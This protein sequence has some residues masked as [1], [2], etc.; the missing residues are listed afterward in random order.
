M[1]G[2][3][4]FGRIGTDAATITV[5]ACS[6]STNTG[7][8]STIELQI[9]ADS[10]PELEAV[11]AQFEC[12]PNPD[13][14]R[15]PVRLGERY[16]ARDGNYEV[17]SVTVDRGVTSGEG[18]LMADVTLELVKFDGH[19][20]ARS[21]HLF[22]ARL[23]DNG[24]SVTE[25]YQR[26]HWAIPSG[27]L[28]CH[29]PAFGGAWTT[30]DTEDGT[31]DFWYDDR[32]DGDRES[33]RQTLYS[34]HT[35]D[36]QQIGA[37]RVEA[38]LGGDSVYRQV[39]GRRMQHGVDW[40]I[41]NAGVR[42]G[43]STDPAASLYVEWWDGTDWVSRIDVVIAGATAGDLLTLTSAVVRRV[44]GPL[45]VVGTTWIAEDEP[46]MGRLSIDLAIA[47]GS[48]TVLGIL[49]CDTDDSFGIR[50]VQSGAGTSITMGLCRSADDAD[51]NRWLLLSSQAM[52]KDGTNHEMHMTTTGGTFIFGV[53]C[54]IG[55]TGASDPDTYTSEQLSFLAATNET[56]RIRE[57]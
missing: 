5:E 49:K 27:W 40:R 53:G 12:Y 26:P 48:R 47:R 51:D 22:D 34:A 44:S 54:E 7:E 50:T 43:P 8:T 11:C 18:A 30:R 42:C 21:E 23:A 4:L 32:A 19:A 52:T 28:V 31:L 46:H 24:L 33:F 25:G 35:V 36:D 39:P 9:E 29:G 14:L 13:E 3:F 41:S 10:L 45:A 37:P 1:S 38:L 16:S 57:W 55:G 17:T 20:A 56:Q 15:V 2:D 6:G